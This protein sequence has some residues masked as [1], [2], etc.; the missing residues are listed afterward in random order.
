[1]VT[2][3]VHA[4]D[5]SSTLHVLNELGYLIAFK[6]RIGNFVKLHIETEHTCSY[7]QEHIKLNNPKILFITY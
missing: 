2:V 6:E 1:M 4:K 3:E 7:V 5:L